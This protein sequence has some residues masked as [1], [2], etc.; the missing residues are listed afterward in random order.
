MQLASFLEDPQYQ[1]QHS[2]HMEII[3]TFGRV[4]PNA[5]PR[6]RDE[7]MKMTNCLKGDFM[8][9][10]PAQCVFSWTPIEEL[11]RIHCLRKFLFTLNWA[12][13]QTLSS[14]SVTRRFKF[15]SLKGHTSF[16]P[17]FFWLASPH[18]Q[19]IWT[20]GGLSFVVWDY[21]IV[22][23]RSYCHHWELRVGKS[24][25]NWPLFSLCYLTYAK[26][27]PCLIWACSKKYQKIRTSLL[28]F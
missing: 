10:F 23:I 20:T 12:W 3:R 25:W 28:F 9:K 14:C 11:C 19:N 16:K 4:G 2:L 26:P 17:T 24:F 7:C 13:V 6:F 15:L 1:D 21:H 27:W 18:N 22:G 8:L 5:E